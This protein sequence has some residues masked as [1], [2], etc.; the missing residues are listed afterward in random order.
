M[1]AGR[2]VTSGQG[3]ELLILPSRAVEL[4]LVLRARVIWVLKLS[5]TLGVRVIS[6]VVLHLETAR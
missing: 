2:G 3:S 5:L 4:A 1:A 6:I